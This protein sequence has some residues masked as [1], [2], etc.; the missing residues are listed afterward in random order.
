MLSKIKWGNLLDKIINNY[1][2]MS[3]SYRG[4]NHL[5]KIESPMMH[6]KFMF[7]FI[8]EKPLVLI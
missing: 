4:I 7:G 6:D 3:F 5:A 1:P 8:S 2:H